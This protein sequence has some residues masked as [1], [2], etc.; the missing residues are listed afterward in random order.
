MAE[1]LN[2]GGAGAGQAQL[3]RRHD[4]GAGGRPLQ[5]PVLPQLALA[6]QSPVEM[7]HS[8]PC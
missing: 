2:T 3:P 5:R 1:L 6:R 7:G 4:R 8:L